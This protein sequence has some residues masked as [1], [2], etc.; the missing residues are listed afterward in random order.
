[1]DWPSSSYNASKPVM[2]H[3]SAWSGT[4]R[5]SAAKRQR[6]SIK[7][8][9]LSIHHA[10]ERATYASLNTKPQQRSVVPPLAVEGV[11]LDHG[12]LG[13][14]T[15]VSVDEEKGGM[16]SAATAGS[17]NSGQRFH[18]TFTA[19]ENDGMDT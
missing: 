14:G 17:V 15:I 19:E 9:R 8:G 7:T 18:W 11:E 5:S 6:Q 13:A 2:P 10:T 16:C 1:M 12:L 3:R 4:S